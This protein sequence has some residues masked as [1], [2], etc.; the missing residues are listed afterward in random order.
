[1]SNVSMFEAFEAMTG[2]PI[3]VTYVSLAFITV[4]LVGFLLVIT[5][6]DGWIRHQNDE[7]DQSDL[8]WLFA[9]AIILFMFMLVVFTP[10]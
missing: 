5:I 9:R 10:A 3:G 2:V 1:M 4:G 8:I 6:K 7:L